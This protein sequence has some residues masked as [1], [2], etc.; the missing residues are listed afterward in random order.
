MSKSRGNVVTP[1]EVVY[2]VAGLPATGYEFRMYDGRVLG[3]EDVQLLGVWQ[4]RA[5]T[6]MFYTS[7][8]T[9]KLPVYL[10]RSGEEE[11]VTLLVEGMEIEQHPQGYVEYYGYARISEV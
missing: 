6:G 10:C 9:G 4:D 8:R 3:R 11:A 7:G 2:G 1:D 5:G